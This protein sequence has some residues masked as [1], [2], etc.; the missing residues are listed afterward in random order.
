M[1]VTVDGN[2]VTVDVEELS[3]NDFLE[4]AEHAILR[5]GWRQG[6]RKKVT[7]DKMVEV[8]EQDGLSLHDAIGYTNVMLGGDPGVP[9]GKDAT[10]RA[11]SGTRSMRNEMTTAVQAVLPKGETDKTFNDKA[12]KVDEVLGVLREARGVKA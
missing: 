1:S 12:K 7:E 6:E 3:V 10:T 5:Y 4:Y 8:A 11:R 2:R 9:S